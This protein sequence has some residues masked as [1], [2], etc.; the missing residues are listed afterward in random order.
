MSLDDFDGLEGF[1]LGVSEVR[2]IFFAF[3]AKDIDDYVR[4]QGVTAVGIDRVVLLDEAIDGG[5]FP[6]DGGRLAVA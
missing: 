1:V 4:R 5:I 3:V 2:V 6:F